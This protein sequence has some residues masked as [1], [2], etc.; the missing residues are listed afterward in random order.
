L[1]EDDEDEHAGYEYSQDYD[2]KTIT[3]N[4]STVR[5][6]VGNNG[7]PFTTLVVEKFREC[8]LL[9]SALG[10]S[11][12][13]DIFG[14]AKVTTCTHNNGAYAGVLDRF[15]FGRVCRVLQFVSA[16][17]DAGDQRPVGVIPLLVMICAAKSDVHILIFLL[18][19]RVPL[20]LEGQIFV[21]PTMIFVRIH[22]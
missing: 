15:R 11:A 22:I 6:S 1:D 19:N 8:V 12:A 10:V 20:L 9:R 2:N 4:L 16:R 18:R 17:F 14:D 7:D 3:A 5:K 21:N 13:R